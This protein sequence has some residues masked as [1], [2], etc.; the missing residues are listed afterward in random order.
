MSVGR[1][2]TQRSDTALINNLPYLTYWKALFLFDVFGYPL[3]ALA[4]EL[5]DA[6]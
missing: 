4:I 1:F 5:N 6:G 2:D 3:E